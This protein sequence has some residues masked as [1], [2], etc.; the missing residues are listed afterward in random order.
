MKTEL[1]KGIEYIMKR[2]LLIAFLIAL[3]FSVIGC[4]KTQ[5]STENANNSKNTPDI[6]EQ[7]LTSEDIDSGKQV[8]KNYF[9]ALNSENMEELKKTLGK[10][11]IESFKKENIGNWK[12]KLDTVEYPG[13]YTNSNIPP[14]SYR[15][16]YGKDPYKSMSLHVTFTEGTEKKDWDY[17][18]V[19]ETKQSSWVIHDW[20]R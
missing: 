4:S 1:L 18:L 6:S 14:S 19:K 9:D 13:K 5:N 11:K 12:P 10:Y 8:V 20:G 15:S 7:K 3:S 16:N 2:L 17:I